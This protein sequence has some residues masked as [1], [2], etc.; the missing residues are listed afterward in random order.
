MQIYVQLFSVVLQIL[1]CRSNKTESVY[2][3]IHT[4]GI[5]STGPLHYCLGPPKDLFL[6]VRKLKRKRIIWWPRRRWKGNIKMDLKELR[7]KSVE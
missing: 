7:W 4:N 2:N 3:F 1:E 6:A 5:S